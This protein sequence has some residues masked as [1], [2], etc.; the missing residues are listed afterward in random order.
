VVGVETTGP[1]VSTSRAALKELYDWVRAPWVETDFETAEMLKLACNAFHALKVCFANEIGNLCRAEGVDGQRVMDV[2]VQDR[3][4]NLSACYL[5]PGAAFGGSCLPKDVG[6][7]NDMAEA[8]DLATPV[9]KAILTS[10]DDQIE[11][12]RLAK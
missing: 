6:A 11:L 5:K 9:L 4:L 12:A 8:N 7:L 1:V 3:N 2:F 10:N